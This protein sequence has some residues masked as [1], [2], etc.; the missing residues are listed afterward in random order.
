M[1]LSHRSKSLMSPLTI[2]LVVAFGVLYMALPFMQDSSFPFV[3]ISS[4]SLVTACVLLWPRAGSDWE[5]KLGTLMAVGALAAGIVSLV[6]FELFWGHAWQDVVFTAVPAI[7]VCVAFALILLM[8]RSAYQA[9]SLQADL[10][11]F[12]ASSTSNDGTQDLE[13]ACEF[14]AR[15]F[16][17]TAREKEVSLLVAHGF[18]GPSIQKQLLLS[19][20][21]V[22]THLRHIYA[23]CS[24][25]TRQDLV[26]LINEINGG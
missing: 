15:R 14:L 24:V 8:M 2:V 19:E 12:P 23:K 20:S 7:A 10:L 16:G 5:L 11:S 26:S 1:L 18:N 22:K 9:Q 25:S 3:L 13:Q 17:L 21:T 6:M 4:F